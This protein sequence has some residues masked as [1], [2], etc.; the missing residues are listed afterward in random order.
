MAKKIWIL[1]LVICFLTI[2]AANAFQTISITQFKV[3]SLECGNLENYQSAFDN[4]N[5]DSNKKFENHIVLN[6]LV[7]TRGDKVQINASLINNQSG[8]GIP[9]QE[10]SFYGP[11]GN[12]IGEAKTNDDGKA[13]Y[14]YTITQTPAKYSLKASYHGSSFYYPTDVITSLD[15]EDG[16]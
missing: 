4:Y 16:I 15:V 14:D 3:G 9:R 13:T 8:K 6:P 10:I 12:I 7:G 2:G 11:D 5:G 1:M